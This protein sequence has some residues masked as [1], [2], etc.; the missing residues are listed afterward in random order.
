MIRH[1]LALIASAAAAASPAQLPLWNPEGSSTRTPI[2]PMI[3]HTQHV[4]GHFHLHMRADSKN[5][6]L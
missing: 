6:W 3:S 2:C 5:R 1:R 4:S